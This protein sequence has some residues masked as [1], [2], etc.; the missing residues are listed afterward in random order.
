[1]S[2][3][4]VK[5]DLKKHVVEIEGQK[6]IPYEIAEKAYQQIFDYDT[7]QKKLDGALALIQASVKSMNETLNIDFN[8]KDSTRKS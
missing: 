5:L 7:N 1:M 8:D 2:K 6:Y 4:V 3:E